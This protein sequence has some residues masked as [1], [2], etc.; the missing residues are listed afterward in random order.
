MKAKF[1][2]HATVKI[3]DLL[4]D[5][6]TKEIE[7]FGLK[8]PYEYTEEDK[9][10]KV[11]CITHNH[12]DHCLGAEELVKEANATLI[13]GFELAAEFLQKGLQA[14]PMNIGGTIEQEGWK[15]YM[16]PAWHSASSNPNGFILQKNGKTFYHAGDTGLF[17]D[18]ERLGKEFSIDIA[19]LPIGDRFTMGI[20]EASKAVQLLKPKLVVPMHYNSFDLIRVNENEFKEKVE[21]AGFACKIVQP[22]QE[23]EI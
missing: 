8:P 5:P 2:G 13:A 22:G 18:M 14:N 15:I 19:F 21:K 23:I 20:D 4:I 16:T 7:G 3:D 10:F 17:E 11:M 1:L 6:W 12:P 9:K